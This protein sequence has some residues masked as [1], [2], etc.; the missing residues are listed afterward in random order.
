[1]AYGGHCNWM[2][3]L[4]VILWC[5]IHVCKPT[6]RRSLLTQ[7]SYYATPT[8]LNGCCK[9]CHCNKHNISAPSKETGAKQFVATGIRGEWSWHV[10]SIVARCHSAK[11]CAYAARDFRSQQN[12]AMTRMWRSCGVQPSHK[13]RAIGVVRCKKEG[14]YCNL[15]GG[16]ALIVW[17]TTNGM[18]VKNNTIIYVAWASNSKRDCEHDLYCCLLPRC[19][20]SR[21]YRSGFPIATQSTAVREH[22]FMQSRFINFWAETTFLLH[23]Y[24]SDLR[25]TI[26]SHI[27]SVVVCSFLIVVRHLFPCILVTVYYLQITYHWCRMPG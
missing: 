4:C 26:S 7:H 10:N 17:F 22:I 5:H 1:M 20:A 16:V 8:L 18:C 25:N 3:C 24:R 13:E 14:C 27:S 12:G 15:S 9:L 6:S 21:A 2:R 23:F 19:E 11:L